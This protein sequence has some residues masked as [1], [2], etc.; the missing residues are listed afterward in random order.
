[1]KRSS[2]C[3][4]TGRTGRT[5]SPPT[6]DVLG[7]RARTQTRRPPFEAAG[8]LEVHRGSDQ[9]VDEL[10]GLDVLDD[11]VALADDPEDLRG[12]LGGRWRSTR[13]SLHIEAPTSRRRWR[14]RRGRSRSARARRAIRGPKRSIASA[15][16]AGGSS[17]TAPRPCQGVS[18]TENIESLLVIPAGMTHS[19][20]SVALLGAGPVAA[21]AARPDGVR[22]WPR[23]PAP[24]LSGGPSY[25]ERKRRELLAVD[26]ERRPLGIT[27]GLLGRLRL[28]SSTLREAVVSSR[29]FRGDGMVHVLRRWLVFEAPAL[30]SLRQRATIARVRM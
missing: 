5:G 27:N 20:R 1:M 12:C 11:A 18:R 10:E 21:R 22:S 19:C 26:F 23:P 17:S 8:G 28:S 25:L 13:G 3:S 14:R 16:V 24:A 7:E 30:A 9:L 2:G 15:I 29:W 6:S 4:S